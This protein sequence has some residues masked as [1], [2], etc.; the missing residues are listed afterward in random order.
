M[1]GPGSHVKKL[2]SS[3]RKEVWP[4][5]AMRL[6]DGWGPTTRIALSRGHCLP[7]PQA[8]SVCGMVDIKASYT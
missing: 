7:G 1:M 2:G 6:C 3:T 4:A 8:S 5:V